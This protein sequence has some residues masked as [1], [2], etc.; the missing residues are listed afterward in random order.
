MFEL[1]AGALSNK[2]FFYADRSSGGEAHVYF[3]TG[4]YLLLE[5]Q[6]GYEPFLNYSNNKISGFLVLLIIQKE[7]I[8]HLI[9]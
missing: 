7:T 4:H 2:I 8:M 3:N 6:N 9:I 1:G 5:I